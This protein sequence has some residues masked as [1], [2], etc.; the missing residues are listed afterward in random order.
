MRSATWDGLPDSS[1]AVTDDSVALY[2]E[3]GRGGVGLIIGGHAF[4]SAIGRTDPN[5][6]GI[7]TDDM[8]PGLSRMTQEAH[9]GGAKIALQINH[10]GGYTDYLADSI[11]RLAVSS[12]ERISTPHKEMTGEEIE[13]IVSEFASAAVRVRE[14]GF[15]A[16]QLHGCHCYLMS[17]FLSPQYNL[18]TDRW[19]GSAENRRRFHLQVIRKVRQA[20]G[21]DFPILIK[22]GVQDDTKGSLSLA[23]GLVT[24]Q[25]MEKEGIDAIEVST[26]MSAEDTFVRPARKGAPEEAYFRELAAAVKRAVS[27]PVMAVGG[28]RSLEMARSIVNSGDAD[29][30]SMCRPFI[31]EPGFVARWQREE[32]EPV[33]NCISCKRCLRYAEKGKPLQCWQG[34]RLKEEA[35]AGG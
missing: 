14:A 26:G 8:V 20:V 19:G 4:I 13:A 12:T 33:N 10:T 18:R 5:Q 3:L 16:I 30:I 27:V 15:D 35:V 7:H 23:E 25:Q 31:H 21:A 9:Q 29:L 11:V 2:R 24:A 32:G 6:Y 17:Q 28:I 1:G 22:L 34:R